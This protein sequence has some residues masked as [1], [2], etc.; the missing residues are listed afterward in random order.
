MVTVGFKLSQVGK[1][2]CQ[3]KEVRIPIVEQLREAT[4]FIFHM[5]YVKKEFPKKEKKE[6][7]TKISEAAP[8]IFLPKQMN[9]FETKRIVEFF[10]FF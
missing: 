6:F 5:N 1:S 4:L 2:N 3:K 7:P 10:Y 9:Y 8:K